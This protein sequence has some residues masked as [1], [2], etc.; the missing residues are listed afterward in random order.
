MT[1]TGIAFSFNYTTQENCYETLQ[2]LDKKK[3][4]SEKRHS[5]GSIK[6]T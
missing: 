2:N 1:A 5:Y 3:K 6:I 4:M